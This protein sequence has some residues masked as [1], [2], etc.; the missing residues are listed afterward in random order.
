MPVHRDAGRQQAREL[1]AEEDALRT[2]TDLSEAQERF[3]A[4]RLEAVNPVM[5]EGFL[6]SVA[7]ASGWQ[8]GPGPAERILTV[9]ATAGS[10]RQRL[11]GEPSR[12]GIRRRRSHR[13]RPRCRGELGSIVTIG[14]TEDAFRQLLGY[15]AEQVRTGA[16][17]GG[18]RHRPG[19]DDRAT[20][21]SSSRPRSTPTTGSPRPP[22][23]PRSSSATRGNAFPVDWTSVANLRPAEG[24]GRPASA[25]VRGSSAIE[26]A[27][28][29]VDEQQ[30]M[31]TEEQA[32]WVRHAR[33]DL[34]SLPSPVAAPTP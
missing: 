1:A 24:D 27:E 13:R 9:T 33:D 3:A 7:G 2:P 17:P 23:L 8:V 14:P 21:C 32:S 31:T 18:G 15:C 12:A 34:D 26:A 29:Y 22:G 30:A 20:R 16:V 4:D 25:R 5:V 6:R 11:G 28:A 19:V 10:C